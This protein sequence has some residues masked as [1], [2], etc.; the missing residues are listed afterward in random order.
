MKRRNHNPLFI[1]DLEGTTGIYCTGKSGNYLNDTILLRSGFRQIVESYNN[2]SINI[3]IATRA[4]NEPPNFYVDAIIRNLKKKGIDLTCKVYT[5]ED[6]QF[7]DPRFFP[8]KNYSSVFKNHFIDFP[9]H[10]SIVLGDFLR[11]SNNPFNRGFSKN[12][13]RNFNFSE[14]PLVLSNNYSLNDHPFPDNDNVPVYAIL[15]QPWTTFEN[16]NLASLDLQVVIKSLLHIYRL[17]N[18][19]FFRGFEAAKN[20][21]SDV[22][23][24]IESDG[25]AQKFLNREC[26][27]KYI[28]FKGKDNDWKPLEQL[29]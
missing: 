22:W 2:N 6:I 28:V 16:G 26:S 14:N 11:F 24:M 3:T 4:P 15:P 13:F 10:D 29:M 27:Q 8:Y 12:Y 19:S 21:S 17:G 9:E 20:K 1:I 25:L 7:S 23:E 18:N 5:K